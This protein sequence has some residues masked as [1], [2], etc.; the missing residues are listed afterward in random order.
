VKSLDRKLTE[1]HADPR[2]AEVLKLP[3]CGARAL[4]ELAAYDPHL[5]PG[6]LGGA[7][8]TTYDAFFLLEQ[9]RRNGARAALLGRKIKDSEHPLSFVAQLR[10][11]ADGQLDAIEGCRAYHAELARL[12][13]KPTR[14]LEQDLQL[15]ERMVDQ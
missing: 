5:I 15:T 4:Q 12:R 6:I 14:P 11:I 7:S 9:A 2:A 1:L 8:G 13:I 3:Y 10:L